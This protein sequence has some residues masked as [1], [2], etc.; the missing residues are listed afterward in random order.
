MN[1]PQNPN[2]PATQQDAEPPT[3]DAHGFNPADFQWVPIP[4][5]TRHDGWTFDTQKR[6]IEMLAD[7]GSVSD[8]A[9]LA[10][11]SVTSCYRLRRTPGAENFAAAWDAAIA[12]SVQRL[13]DIAMDRAINGAED[14]VLDRNGRVMFIRRKYNDRLLMF[15]LRAHHPE[16][17]RHQNDPQ[18][19][20]P[21]APAPL[22]PAIESLAPVTPAQPQLINPEAYESLCDTI[23][24]VREAEAQLAKT[25]AEPSRKK[26][27]QAS[28]S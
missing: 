19:T 8:A 1:E 5:R 11:M 13:V 9:H 20:L 22:I 23:L 10:G 18:R 6:F 27:V 2:L 3:L 14:P 4:R 21:E 7:T 26:R 12:Q 15:L 28:P 16:R 25:P 17:Y 24:S